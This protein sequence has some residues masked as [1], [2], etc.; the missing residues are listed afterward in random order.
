[1]GVMA[2]A[3]DLIQRGYVG[4]EIQ[5]GVLSFTPKPNE[6]LNGLSFRLRFR[7][8]P[9]EIT[10]KEKSLLVAP[11]ADGLGRTIEIRVGDKSWEIKDEET[12]AFTL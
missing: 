2:G 11:H 3:L 10:L 1:M 4:A 12:Y 7:T 6:R 9:L 8:M 5:D